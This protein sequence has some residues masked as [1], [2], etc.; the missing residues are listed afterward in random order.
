MNAR[1][2]PEAA[3]SLPQRH[4]LRSFD[5]F[6]TLI[7]RRCIE[8]RRVF[9]KLEA[10]LGMPGF[11]AARIAAEQAVATGAYTLM[12]IYAELAVGLTAGLGDE[13]RQCTEENLDHDLADAMLAKT[14]S[15]GENDAE[16]EALL[17]DLQE[18][19]DL[20]AN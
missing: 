3:P 18:H 19:C 1:C 5:V 10:Q 6:D 15:S 20:P 13:L 12:D 16:F 4:L 9:D 7:A 17:A 2:L 11:A 8:P 14:F